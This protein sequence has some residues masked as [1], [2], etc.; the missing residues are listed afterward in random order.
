[1]STIVTSICFPYRTATVH[2]LR[3]LPR[4]NFRELEKRLASLAN[5]RGDN[6][7]TYVFK[8]NT[9]KWYTVAYHDMNVYFGTLKDFRADESPLHITLRG[10]EQSP[11]DKILSRLFAEGLDDVANLCSRRWNAYRSR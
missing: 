11:M 2:C 10:E 9:D 7:T 5:V 3:E 8:T 4:A 1:M 6:H